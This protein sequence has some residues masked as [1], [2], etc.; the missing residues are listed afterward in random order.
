[1]PRSILGASILTLVLC[2]SA[3]ASGATGLWIDIP[4]VQQQKDGCGAAAVAMVM[5]YWQRHQGLPAN[6]NAEYAHIDQALL[7]PSARGIYASSMERYLQ[8][9]GYRTFAFAGQR[10]DLEHNLAKGRPLIAALKPGA[11]LPLH[12]VVVAGLD[13]DQHT[14]L[15]NDPAQRKLLQEDDLQ[16]EKEWKAAGNWTLLAVPA[17]AGQ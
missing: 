5:Q 1:M 3:F 13:P 10:A 17:A 11:G 6:R 2:G 12:Y 14:V 15:L 7:S 16:F 8:Q 4:F 9:N